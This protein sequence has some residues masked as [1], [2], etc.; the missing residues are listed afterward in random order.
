M[1]PVNLSKLQ[2]IGC[3]ILLLF[4]ASAYSSTLLATDNPCDPTYVSV[5]ANGW[6]VVTASAD[7]T[8][9]TDTTNLN[10]TTNAIEN[11]TFEKVRLKNGDFHI[12]EVVLNCPTAKNCLFSGTTKAGTVVNI[13]DGS[14]E[15]AAQWSNLVATAGITVR[16]SATIRYM[17]LT[18]D[19]PCA[20][21]GFLP[22]VIQFTGE[23]AVL[24][25]PVTQ[26]TGCDNG[27]TFSIFDRVDIHTS[28]E[29]VDIG[30][31]VGP[32]SHF[33]GEAC[34]YL[35]TGTFNGLRNSINGPYICAEI[36]MQGRA[37]TGLDFLVARNCAIGVF[38]WDTGQSLRITRA[39]ILVDANNDGEV[40]GIIA[41]RTPDGPDTTSISLDQ[42]TVEVRS[43]GETPEA[44]GVL[45]EDILSSQVV[46]TSASSKTIKKSGSQPTATD[47]LSTN[48]D[49]SVTNTSFV[50]DG[51]QTTV[52]RFI[53]V[54]NGRF[55]ANEMTGNGRAGVEILLPV[56]SVPVAQAGYPAG[57]EDDQPVLG[58]YAF[59]WILANILLA[60]PPLLVQTDMGQAGVNSSPGPGLED[61]TVALDHVF[62][63]NGTE[64]NII[65]LLDGGIV[66]DFG[67]NFNLNA[68][69]G[70]CALAPP[71]FKSQGADL[72]SSSTRQS[73][74]R[75][76]MAMS[77][78]SFLRSRS[79][80]RG[81]RSI[82]RE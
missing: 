37:R 62:T 24:D 47:A 11:G 32:Q 66:L 28:T 8:G 22:S 60:Q 34:P 69:D 33:F 31:F 61:Y 23:P 54:D 20:A 39:D 49:V 6:F 71:I 67:C 50:L 79:D 42:S 70:G 1:S 55:S 57:I 26:A 64:D 74:R 17:T 59:G 25:T 15:C 12:S 46:T 41:I 78:R 45:V 63:A 58:A 75:N 21:D 35:L 43:G 13:V 81:R 68:V 77:A 72:L 2:R 40:A 82:S 73:Q 3:M 19:E 4:L 29:E 76:S 65:G 14:I 51:S 53:N 27:T 7:L 5:D 80:Y 9:V 16:G 56:E 18:A 52:A 48:I 36:D 44:I 10:C 38:T 30:V